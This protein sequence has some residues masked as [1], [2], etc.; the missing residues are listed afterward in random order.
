[1]LKYLATRKGEELK[2]V[3]FDDAREAY[4]HIQVMANGGDITEYSVTLVDLWSQE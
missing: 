4:N 3:Y 2:W 1:M